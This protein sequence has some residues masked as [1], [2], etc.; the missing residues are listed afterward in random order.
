MDVIMIVLTFRIMKWIMV[1]ILNRILLRIL[2]R[3]LTTEHTGGWSF[4]R[5]LTSHDFQMNRRSLDC[6]YDPWRSR[7]ARLTYNVIKHNFWYS[8]EL[9][10]KNIVVQYMLMH[11]YT[12]CIILFAYI[13]MENKIIV[14]TIHDDPG[15]R[16]LLRIF[17][18]MIPDTYQ[19]YL[20]RIRL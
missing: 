19:S 3:I 9:F 4:S 1:R 6:T 13:H 14:P 12:L 5:S 11:T 10:V 16:S 18:N 7:T 8:L 17:I 15:T 2:Y 20:W